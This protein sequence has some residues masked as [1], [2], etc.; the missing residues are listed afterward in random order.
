TTAANWESRLKGNV[1]N[2]G[3]RAVLTEFGDTMNGGT[4]YTG[5]IGGSADI[6]SIQGLT[7]EVR[8]LG[9]GAVYWPGIR[10]GDSYAMLQ[11]G[12]SAASP[13]VTNTN[14]SGLSRLKYAWG[15]GTG[16]TDIFYPTAYYRLLN[17]NSGNALDVNGASTADG[18]G[19][20]QWQQNGGNN[21]QW[22]ITANGSNYKITNRNSGLALDINGASKASGAGIIQ[23][24]WNGGNNQQWSLTSVSPGV[25][26]VT[27]FNSGY[28]V[29][30]MSASKANGA[31]IIQSPPDGG[32]NQQW[33]IVQ[34]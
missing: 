17:V 19:I 11:L 16:G 1:G 32:T 23:W 7:N 15:V 26:K 33:T 31:I 30:V 28:L 5:A 29:D 12:G 6:A 10:N 20:I 14:A 21:Q 8:A 13:I 4:N 2:Y 24:P 34:Q 3:S 27:N 22:T 18:A 9:M 25:Y